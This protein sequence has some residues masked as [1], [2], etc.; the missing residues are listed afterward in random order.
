MA[1]R[2][3]IRDES[4]ITQAMGMVAGALLDHHGDS[5]SQLLIDALDGQRVA[6]CQGIETAANVQQG[7][8]APG[9]FAELYQTFPGDQGIVGIDAGNV[10]GIRGGPGECVAPPSAHA[11]KCR[12]SGKPVLFYEKGVPGIPF[13]ARVGLDKADVKPALEQF[14]LSLWLVVKVPAAPGPR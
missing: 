10:V 5:A 6:A 1:L 2:N 11:D 12:P 9:Q 7:H 3:E 8:V 4:R 14:N 13:L